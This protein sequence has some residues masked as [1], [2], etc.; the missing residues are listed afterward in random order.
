MEFFPI[1]V[2]V[3]LWGDNIQNKK[4]MFNSDNQAVVAIL[5]KLTS[6]SPRVMV[7]VRMFVLRC[8]K[9][10]IMVRGQYIPGTMN[11]IADAL[12]RFQF[13][14]FRQ[15]VP[16]AVPY[17]TTIPQSLWTYWMQKLRGYQL[18]QFPRTRVRLM[19]KLCKAFSCFAQGNILNK[20]GQLQLIMLYIIFPIFLQS[21]DHLQ[22]PTSMLQPFHDITSCL[23]WTIR[24]TI[25]LSENSCQE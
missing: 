24:L 21:I 22:Q 18:C 17:P 19:E 2:A 14:R 23:P 3:F 13:Q 5:N 12:S 7:L 10:N 15:S 6:S 20:Y 4:I 1:L 11:H 16:Q 9:L 25:T 8:M